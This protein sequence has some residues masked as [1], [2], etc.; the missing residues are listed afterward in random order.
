MDSWPDEPELL[1]WD[2][3]R[4]EELDEA[5]SFPQALSTIANAMKLTVA[6]RLIATS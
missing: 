1:D 2:D 3:S 4:M 6:Q 5:A